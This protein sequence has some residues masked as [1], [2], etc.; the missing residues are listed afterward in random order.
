MPM[1]RFSGEKVIESLVEDLHGRLMTRE[2]DDILWLITPYRLPNGDLVEVAVV[3][4]EDDRFVVTDYGE[5]GRFLANHGYDPLATPRGR[6]VLEGLVAR[7]G[8]EKALPEIRKVTSLSE[9]GDAVFDVILGCIALGDMLYLS[10]A[11]QPSEFTDRVAEVVRGSGL[12]ATKNVSVKGKSGTSYR[13]H[14]SLKVQGGE[15]GGLLQTMSP[16]RPSGIKPM[17]DAA[18]RMW[19][20]LTDGHWL[21]TVVDDSLFPWPMEHLRILERLSCVYEWSQKEALSR[22]FPRV[23]RTGKWPDAPRQ[24]R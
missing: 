8:I 11:Y 6:E 13:I 1:I 5:T 17:T 21:G 7:T 22:D 2:E 16:K 19:L 23:S 10:R 12:V 24:T 18:V 4:L 14:F 15:R 20:D 9:L 3:P